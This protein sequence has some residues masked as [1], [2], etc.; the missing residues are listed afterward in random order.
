MSLQVYSDHFVEII[1]TKSNKV[2]RLHSFYARSPN[3]V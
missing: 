1:S 2:E 3:G